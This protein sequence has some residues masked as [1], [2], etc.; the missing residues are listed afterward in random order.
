MRRAP[1]S[2]EGWQGWD[3]YA[4]FYDWEN[5]QTLGRR[6]VP[7]WRRA[8]LKAQGP[9]L[10]LGCGTGRVTKS[11]RA[12]RRRYRRHRS[13]GANARPRALTKSPTHQVTNSRLVRGDIRALPFAA[14]SFSMVLAP[15]GILQSLTRP[16]RSHRDARLGGSCRRARRHLR[17]RSRAGRPEVARVRQQGAAARPI[18]RRRSHA[19]R[20]GTAG[21]A[22][23]TDDL[24]AALRRTRGTGAR[25]ITASSWSFARSPCR[26]CRRQLERAGFRVEAVL[27]DYRGRAV[28]RAGRRVDHHGAARWDEGSQRS[29][30]PQKIG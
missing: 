30:R 22:P 26:R 24:R 17:D 18:G 20:I 19:D 27:G 3:E 21:P 29:L 28:G 2:R 13:I 6:D 4:P 8:A 16:R 5:A 9:V 15:Y 7:F 12:R 14:R 11:A 25:A 1:V 10:E 23:P